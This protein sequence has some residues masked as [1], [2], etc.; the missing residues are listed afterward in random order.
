MSSNRFAMLSMDDDDEDGQ[1]T[2]NPPPVVAQVPPIVVQK[3]STKPEQQRTWNI[4]KSRRFRQ[5][6][7]RG[8]AFHDEEK[9]TF[10]PLKAYAFQDDDS[11]KE[12][13]KHTS[14]VEAPVS[15]P[16]RPRVVQCRKCEGEHWTL[17]CTKNAPVK[18]NPSPEFV[19]VQSDEQFPKLSDYMRPQT[20]PYPP[21]DGDYPTLAERVK[22]SIEKDDSFKP[23]EPVQT[24]EMMTVIP[25]RS[26][27]IGKLPI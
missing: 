20:P 2:T 23:I 13:V 26:T 11:S 24:I 19:V 25:M 16:E 22:R 8:Y 14:P 17:S 3:P 6:F 10:T 4:D 21:D 1:M 9:P 7:S 12:S 18:T 15:L 27:L 5:P